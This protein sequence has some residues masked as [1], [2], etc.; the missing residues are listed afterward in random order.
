MKRILKKENTKN[1]LNR[2][3]LRII[4]ELHLLRLRLQ[5][6]NWRLWSL[7]RS[8]YGL[9]LTE[10]SRGRRQWAGENNTLK[11]PVY[12]IRNNIEIKP[13]TDKICIYTLLFTLE[14]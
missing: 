8:S 5:T 10:G 9:L 6:G 11:I 4:K 2:Y 13:F 7:E 3:G 1:Y 14:W 12:S